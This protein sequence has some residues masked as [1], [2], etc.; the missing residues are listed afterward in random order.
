MFTL[1]TRPN[2]IIGALSQRSSL[3]Q[4]KLLRIA[5]ACS[6]CSISLLT[7]KTAWAEETVPQ[8]PAQSSEDC[9]FMTHN[10]EMCSVDSD[11]KI[12]CSTQFIAC[13]PTKRWCLVLKDKKPQ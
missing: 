8:V 6:F 13:V 1:K 12:L 10:C 4:W 5:V 2:K 9:A 7:N 11:G 3:I